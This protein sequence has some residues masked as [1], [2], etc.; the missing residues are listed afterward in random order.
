MKGGD[1][2]MT[3]QQWNDHKQH[4]DEHITWP[5]N[6]EEIVAACKGMDVEKE[7]LEEV[8]TKLSDGNRKYTKEEIKSMLVM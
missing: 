4:M 3:V 5:A 7:V 8:K 6:K 1:F 2:F